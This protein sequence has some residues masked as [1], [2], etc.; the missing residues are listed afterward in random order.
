[1]AGHDP[2]YISLTGVLYHSGDPDAPPQAPP[3]LLGDSAGGAAMVAWGI[4][5][6]LLHAQRT[7][8]GQVVDGAIVDGIAYLAT[9]AR[10]FYQAGHIGDQR[11]SDWMDGAAPWN[12]SYRCADGGYITLCPVEA[13]FYAVLV[14]KLQL[15]EHPLFA[16][17]DQWDRARWPRQIEHLRS[18]FGGESRQHWCD[19]L[20]GTDACFA[21]VLNYGEVQDHP[22]NRARG[23]YVE[24]DGEWYPRPAPRFSVTVPEPAWED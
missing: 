20:E 2:N 6:A 24:V 9:F 13:R 11:G 18:L 16:D 19:L 8:Q 4:S 1:V 14:E 17:L 12:R 5:T 7:G 3:T 23:S 10:S 15:I 22:H 21:P